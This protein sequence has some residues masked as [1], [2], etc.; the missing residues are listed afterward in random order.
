[1]RVAGGLHTRHQCLGLQW[2][3]RRHHIETAAQHEDDRDGS[4]L[5]DVLEGSALD[6]FVHKE[7]IVTTSNLQLRNLEHVLR[8]GVAQ[9]SGVLKAGR[10]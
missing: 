5:I 7:G 2:A 1:M 6:L 9:L 10:V 8:A 4:H 3:V